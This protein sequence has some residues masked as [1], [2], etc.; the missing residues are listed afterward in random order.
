MHVL[1]AY[2][3]KML[4]LDIHDTFEKEGDVCETGNRLKKTVLFEGAS[5]PQRELYRR[6]QV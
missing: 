4:A 5:E 2:Q 6:F 3:F 1:N